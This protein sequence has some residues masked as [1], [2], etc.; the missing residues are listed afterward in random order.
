MSAFGRPGFTR[1]Q[2]S[3]KEMRER[4]VAALFE[5][6]FE[7][8]ALEDRVA[9]L[10]KAVKI[11]A[12]RTFLNPPADVDAIVA[13]VDELE[14]SVQRINRRH[15]MREEAVALRFHQR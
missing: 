6:E 8:I 15:A 4:T 13:R 11:L 2:L 12:E 14:Q 10:E 1:P 7:N 9:R 3:P 5:A